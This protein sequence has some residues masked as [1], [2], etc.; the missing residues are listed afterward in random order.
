MAIEVKFTGLAKLGAN[1][2][3][4]TWISSQTAGWANLRILG[5]PCDFQVYLGIGQHAGEETLGERL[6]GPED[7]AA[8]RAG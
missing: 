5:Q 8:G 6:L 4:L 3:T 7:L 1:F 2:K